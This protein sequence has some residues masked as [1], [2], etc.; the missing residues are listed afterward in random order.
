VFDGLHPVFSV[1]M[2]DEYIRISRML[3]DQVEMNKSQMQKA[4]RDTKGSNS[5]CDATMI[6]SFFEKTMFAKEFAVDA[7]DID[8]MTFEEYTILKALQHESYEHRNKEM[9]ASKNKSRKR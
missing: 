2:M 9:Q 1:K 7:L 4:L 6:G 3:K 5:I 8:S